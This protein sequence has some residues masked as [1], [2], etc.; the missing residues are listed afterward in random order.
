ME[1]TFSEARKLI[2]AR[3]GLLKKEPFGRGKKAALKALER[4]GYVQID[5]ISVIE[6]AH[7]HTLWNRVG[8]YR[9]KLLYDM[10]GKDRTVMEYWSHAAA[11]LPM[12]HYRYCL[13]NM[14]YVKAKGHHWFHV[15]SK[16]KDYVY[17]RIVNE[18]ALYARDFANT[19]K[20]SGEMWDLKPAK[21]A[22]HELFMEGTL[23][24]SARDNFHRRYDLPERV[25]PPAVDTSL[26]SPK[27]QATHYLLSAIGAQGLVSLGAIHYLRNWIKPLIL[28]FLPELIEEG[29]V[30]EVTIHKSPGKTFFTTPDH[31]QQVPKRANKSIYFLSPFDNA[32]IQR[33]R[34]G[35]FFN[36]DYQTEIYL[37]PHK[38]VYGYFALPILWG[39]DFIGRLDPKA[40][41]K[42]GVLVINNL[43]IEPDV[44]A[45]DRL[46][47]ALKEA[48]QDFA[49]FNGC[50]HFKILKSEPALLAGWLNKKS[51]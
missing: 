27:E 19:V 41:R 34:L 21:K 14:H 8:N 33:K 17:Q 10:L 44:K 15:D 37:P 32:I 28:Q 24:V 25:L 7:H 16:V 26:P 43:Q 22:L 3:Q 50:Q 2:L 12:N 6:R 35:Y 40:E 29:K 18:G 36:F 42:T 38:R 30:Q 1:I 13:H 49:L 9:P 5:A 39:T 20:L 45:S 23:L 4:L 11:F 31:L 46:L 47:W 48:L 51:E